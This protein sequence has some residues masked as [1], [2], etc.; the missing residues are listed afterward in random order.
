MRAVRVEFIAKLRFYGLLELDGAAQLIDYQ[1]AALQAM[2]NEW[3]QFALGQKQ[4]GDDLIRA[5][6]DDFRKRQAMF[7]IE[8]LVA[9]KE[10]ARAVQPID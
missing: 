6:V 2:L 10:D 1:I 9:C 3:E 8:W 5:W 4:Q 7:M